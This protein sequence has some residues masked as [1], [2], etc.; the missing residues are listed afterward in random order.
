M[1]RSRQWMKWVLYALLVGG[2]VTGVISLWSDSPDKDVVATH[3]TDSESISV[4][5]VEAKRGDIQ[6]WVFADGTARSVQ[7]E[8]LIFQNAG[9]V[10]Y[11]KDGLREG[12]HVTAGEELA[13]QDQRQYAADIAAARASLKEAKAQ[14]EVSQAELKQAWTELRLAEKKFQRFAVLLKQTSASQQEYDQAQ[15]EFA[16]TR[17]TVAQARS[18]IAAA[19]TQI[20]S[21]KARL[22][23]EQVQLEDTTLVSPIDGVVAYSNINEGGY[24]MPN[25]VRTDTEQAAL[26]TVPMVVIDPDRFEII[27]QVPSYERSRIEAGQLALIAP[28]GEAMQ[29]S[30]TK[31]PIEQRFPSRG[32]I[33]SLTPA[34]SPGGRSIEVKIRTTHGAE[35]LKDGMFVTVWIATAS[36]HDVVLAP[37]DTFVYR[38]NQPFVFAVSTEDGIVHER[39]VE[40]GLQGFA[41]QEIV[42]GVQAGERLVTEGRFQ[43]SDGVHVRMLGEDKGEDT[44]RMA[45]SGG[46]E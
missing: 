4:T 46:D 8:Y 7:R 42:S 26:Q 11:I 16:R 10:T 20:E 13:H 6:E 38:D 35:A 45:R 32:E 5:A 41:N 28:S 15:A 17:E 44:N 3:P 39:Q 25:I 29:Q 19:N 23:Q 31:G 24:F 30:N 1:T 21:A 14:K 36:H 40:L 12:S 34:I 27:V 43:V 37:L 18:R 33:Y 22:D 9:R 2:G